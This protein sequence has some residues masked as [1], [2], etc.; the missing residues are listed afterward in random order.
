VKYAKNYAKRLKINDIQ[1]GQLNR[2]TKLDYTALDANLH[3]MS[4]DSACR[5][6]MTAGNKMRF[7]AIARVIGHDKCRKRSNLSTSTQFRIHF[8]RRSVSSVRRQLQETCMH[9]HAARAVGWQ[10]VQRDS[11]CRFA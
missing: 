3:A 10:R 9:C 5:S 8:D 11:A 1:S 6:P 4:P 7:D 2:F